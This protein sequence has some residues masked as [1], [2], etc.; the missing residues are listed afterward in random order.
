MSDRN[1]TLLPVS[2]F[3]HYRDTNYVSYVLCSITTLDKTVL[4]GVV[5]RHWV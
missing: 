4:A 3:C 1:S 2:V 5:H